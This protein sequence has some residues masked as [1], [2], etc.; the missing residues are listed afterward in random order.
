V[1]QEAEH[2]QPVIDR[3]QYDA[4]AAVSLPVELHLMAAPPW[5]QKATGR[6]SPAS[7]AGVQ[8]FRY[9]QSSLLAG[10]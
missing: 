5:I 3:H 6:F 7:P 1:C 8:I 4:P 9:R 2:A 10:I